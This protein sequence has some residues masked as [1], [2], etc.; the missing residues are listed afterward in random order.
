MAAWT[1]PPLTTIR[2]PTTTLGAWAVKRLIGTLRADTRQAERASLV[3]EL[4]VRAST[5]EPP[6]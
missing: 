2:Q 3:P 5:G 4:V 1:D 6:D